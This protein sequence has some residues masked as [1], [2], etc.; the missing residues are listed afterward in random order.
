MRNANDKLT[1]FIATSAFLHA[2][3]IWGVIFAPSLFPVRTE[4]T[5]G[6]GAD[7]T[8][9]VGVTDSL[10]GIPLPSPPVVQENAK[11]NDS[12]TLNPVEVA[13]KPVEK[14]PPP[15]PA[16][17]KVP[18]GTVKPEKKPE[19]K[20]KVA[21]GD[22][23]PNVTPPNAVPGAGGQVALPYGSSGGGAGQAT[24]GG[25]G[26]F[27]TRF[28]EYVTAMTRAITLAWAKPAGIPPGTP[29][30]YV[31]FTIDRRGQASN[32]AIAESSGSVQLDNSAQRAVLQARL[33]SLPTAYTGSAVDVRYYFEYT[34]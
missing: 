5:W 33:P 12:D 13:P 26:T 9:R 27:G 11:P 3:L 20:P 25:D 22:V 2:G 21:R 29:R 31:T 17:V 32:V 28:P 15:A 6:T 7:R 1:P 23:P 16:E 34:R 18:S 30:V 14:T 24:F 10:P 4:A 19:P 8:A